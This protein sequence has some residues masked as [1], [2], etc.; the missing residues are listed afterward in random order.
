MNTAP[1]SALPATPDAERVKPST[2]IAYS[3]SAFAENLALN[4]INQLANPVFN[5]TLGVSPVLVGTAI[6]LPRLW[7][8]FLDIWIGNAS[9]QF[10]SRWGRRRPFIL[11]GALLTAIC[12]AGIWFF[13]DGRSPMFYFG[14]LTTGS[15]LLTTAYSIFVVP[16]GALGLEL[17]RDYQER[18]RLMGAKSMLHK[19]SGLVNQWL[20][21]IVQLVGQNNLVAGSR[22]CGV[23][24][25]FIVATLGAITVWR[26]PERASPAIA[27]AGPKISLWRSWRATVKRRDFVRL[28]LAQVLIYASVLIVDNTG[29][30]LNVFYVNGG[31]MA[32]GAFI[33]GIAGMCFH[34]GGIAAIPGIVWLSHRTSKKN[35]LLFCTASI[36]VA[37]ITKWFCYVPNAGWL[38]VIP[39]LL[40]APGLVAVMVLVPSMTADICDLDEVTT[41]IR[42]EG[43]F[44]AVLGWML[45]VAIFGSIFLAGLALD[46]TGWQTKLMVAQSPQTFLAMRITF[47]AG[48]I[49]FALAAA[50]L[51]SGYRVTEET[52]A[53]SR[54]IVKHRSA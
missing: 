20:L 6:A 34:L 8:V 7:D 40:L 49:F 29:F 44:N 27:T 9:D 30:Y 5:L 52:V 54:R 12:A 3:T 35:T 14:W 37:G 45:K 31:D 18:T 50:A 39:S 41:G 11:I 32:K 28:A 2:Q 21:K 22:F 38:L 46:L 23:I 16:Y 26:V 10:Q 25:G 19:L 33:K 4:S 47:S 51:I 15:F 1:K 43:M 17:T 48:T 13:P 36:L 42:R 53:E 24:I